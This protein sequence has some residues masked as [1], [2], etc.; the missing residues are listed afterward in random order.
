MIGYG[1]LFKLFVIIIVIFLV[2]LMGIYLFR[3][4]RDAFT[5]EDIRDKDYNRKHKEEKEKR[6]HDTKMKVMDNAKEVFIDSTGKIVKG[7]RILN[8][9]DGA[10]AQVAVK[11]VDSVN[12]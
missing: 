2:A 8:S 10:L 9:K 11:A 6:S 1:D 4:A 3:K 5:N 7:T 12:K